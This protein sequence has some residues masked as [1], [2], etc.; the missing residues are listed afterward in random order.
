VK[1]KLDENLPAE[2]SVVLQSKGHDVHTVADE[3]LTAASDPDVFAAVVRE[4]RMFMTQDLDFSDVRKFRPGTHPGIALI[5][6]REPSRRVLIQRLREVF[7]I[8][9]VENW[10]QCFVVISN[11]KLRVQTP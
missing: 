5:R 6:L 1:I 7:E 10:T 2:L 8:E 3:G 4:G 11:T 9:P